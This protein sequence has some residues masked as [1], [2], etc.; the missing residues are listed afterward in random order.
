MR[1]L[2]DAERIFSK[3]FTFQVP[4]A[5]ERALCPLLGRSLG[6]HS[7]LFMLSGRDRDSLPDRK[8]ECGGRSQGP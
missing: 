2:F 3:T 5:V 8:T 7:L 1:A 4:N 6:Y